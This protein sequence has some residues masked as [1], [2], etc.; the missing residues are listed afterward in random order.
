MKIP[1]RLAEKIEFF[2][3]NGRSFREDEE[4]FTTTSWFAVLMGQGL[5]PRSYDPVVNSVNFE[6]T[7]RRLDE[8]QQVVI[9]SVNYMPSHDDFIK[10]NCSAMM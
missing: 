9:N 1:D 2:K 4:L 10:Q 8:L 6:E 3:N 7:K 5:K